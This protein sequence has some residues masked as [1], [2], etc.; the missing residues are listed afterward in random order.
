MATF[1]GQLA[2]TGAAGLLPFLISV[3]ATMV[4]AAAGM[5]L[6]AIPILMSGINR[7]RDIPIVD[8]DD[9]AGAAAENRDVS[10]QAV[11]VR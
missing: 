6:A 2:G 5:A 4:I 1:A 3:R 9:V 8:D 7:L 11:G 10:E